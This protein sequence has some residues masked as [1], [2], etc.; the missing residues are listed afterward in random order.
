MSRRLNL[1]LSLS[2]ILVLIGAGH[3]AAGRLAER[4]AL[5]T[6]LAEAGAPIRDLAAK[7]FIVKEDGQK[8]EVVLASLA[9]DQLNVALMLD[10]AQP[11]RG[12]ALPTQEIGR[13]HV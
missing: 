9:T 1:S 4:A 2:A 5:V 10:V 11:P 3:P 7:D 6:V 13:A 8:R 12:A